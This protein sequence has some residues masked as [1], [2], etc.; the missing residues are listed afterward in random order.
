MR[1]DI[2]A[3][4]FDLDDTLYDREAAFG[5]WAA[6]FVER[7]LVVSDVRERQ[8]VLDWIA[9][10]DA[11][12]Y[13]SKHAMFEALHRRY[14]AL[15]D[16]ADTSIERFFEELLSEIGPEAETEALLGTLEGAGLPF[17]VVTN[18]SAR[19]WNKIERLGLGARTACLFVSET[20]GA[21]K[22]EPAIFLAAAECL[23]VAPAE[24]LFVG[25]HPT[26][27]VLGARG[28]GMKTAWLHRGKPWPPGD[29]PLAKPDL[30]LDR[31]TDLLP[32]LTQ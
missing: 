16:S 6:A 7:W 4:L 5:R 32:L 27:D 14:P 22:P 10:L 24:V 28:V 23:G 31:L 1:D 20:F 18:G 13:G 30:T 21:R 17:G 2:R 8:E 19:Q 29:D 9:S 26:N 11:S 12:G 3:V 25:D 15:G